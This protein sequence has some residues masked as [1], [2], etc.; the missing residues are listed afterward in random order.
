MMGTVHS[1]MAGRRACVVRDVGSD[2]ERGSA[3]REGDNTDDVAQHSAVSAAVASSVQSRWWW[4]Y[5]VKSVVDG[6]HVCL[7]HEA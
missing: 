3:A 1:L 7:W 5:V 2:G 6:M 4:R